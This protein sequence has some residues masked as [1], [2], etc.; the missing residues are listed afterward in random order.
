VVEIRGRAG[1]EHGGCGGRVDGVAWRR[2]R[3]GTAVR[4]LLVVEEDG[5]HA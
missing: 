3:S 4:V 5:E 2:G 1:N